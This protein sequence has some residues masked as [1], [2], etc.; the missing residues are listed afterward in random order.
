[1]QMKKIGRRKFLK[2]LT[3][4]PTH[5]ALSSAGVFAAPRRY[6]KLVDTTRCIGCKRC[7][8][9]CK[10]WNKL[11]VERTELLTDWETDLSANNWVVVNLR[12]DT[13][14]REQRLYHHWTCQHCERPACAGV[15]PVTAI[16]KLPMGPVV[17]DENKCIGCRYCFQACPF[18]IPRFDFKKRVTRKC[19]LCYDRTPLLNYMKPACVAACPVAALSF[20]YKDAIT[21]EAMRR[22]GKNKNAR[23]IMGL[24]E[25]G[26]TD[27]LTILSGRPGNFGLI[28][29]PH[30][31]VNHWLD[32]I[33]I[34]A[35]GLMGASVIAGAMWAY[36]ELNKAI[37]A[38]DD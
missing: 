38:A 8:S 16:S 11:E 36:S 24:K 1:M 3:G 9:A 20:G 2:I 28:A 29:A 23:Y 7:M 22:V 30:K 12:A 6:G 17:I 31:V 27:V 5:A 34:T 32:K 37:G 19:T 35:S 15:C 10:R 25:A 33:R 18:K 14:N 13:A 21:R 26:G 4:V